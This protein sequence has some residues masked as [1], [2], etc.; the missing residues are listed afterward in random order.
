MPAFAIP[1]DEL[2]AIA[3]FVMLLRE[4]GSRSSNDARSGNADAGAKLYTSANGAKCHMVRGQGGVLGPDLSNAG[5]NRTPAQLEQALRNPGAAAPRR[6]VPA[7]RAVTVR[8]YYG[9]T[10]RGIA[11]NESP[12]DLQL[13][14]IDGKMHL[15]LKDQL[16]EVVH[17]KSL[18]PKVEASD[19]EIRDLVAYLNDLRT[20]SAVAPRELGAGLSFLD[21]AHPK[22][23]TW[24]TYHGNQSGNRFS[25]LDQIN[26]TNVAHLAPTW[27]FTLPGAGRA[28]QVT[29]VVAD[30]VMYVTGVNEAYALDARGGREIWHYSR[31]RTPGLAG[32]A[33]G[34]INRGVAVLGDRIF[35]VTDNAHLI[36]LHRFTGQLLW[37]VEM[38]DSRQNYGATGAPL[39]AFGPSP[40]RAS[41]DRTRGWVERGNTD[42][43][44][45]GSPAPTIRS[46]TCSFGPRAIHVLTTTATN[47]RAT[48]SIVHRYWRS[49]PRQES[50]N[51]ITS[52]RRMICMTGML[53]R[54]RCWLMRRFTARPASSY[55]KGIVTASF[56]CSIA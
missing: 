30:G 21:V 47:A 28:L 14:S 26:T 56:M 35:M 34:G 37:D 2:D 17:E 38:A 44:R 13:L 43:P 41:R 25:M 6:G 49:I 22:P 18:M 48:I 39:G 24:P 36:S 46:R 55:C 9:A 32:D 50:S 53:R 1:D 3:T 12:F 52:L 23:G 7:Y 19:S 54:R 33:A 20:A 45:R 29:P 51:G 27:M 10:L 4:L 16:A 42:A 15:L 5:Q 8:M 31:P 11:E 40:R